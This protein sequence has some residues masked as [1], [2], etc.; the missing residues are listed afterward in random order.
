MS[1]REASRVCVC[2]RETTAVHRMIPGS[3]SSAINVSNASRS[4][5]LS[6]AHRVSHPNMDSGNVIGM[7]PVSSS[8]LFPLSLSLDPL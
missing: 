4:Q 8:A 7:Q 3:N 2:V 1:E 5:L 6:A